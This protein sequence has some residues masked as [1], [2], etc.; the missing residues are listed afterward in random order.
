SPCK[1]GLILP[2][3][4]KKRAN[5]VHHARNSHRLRSRQ[6]AHLTLLRFRLHKIRHRNHAVDGPK[7]SFAVCRPLHQPGHRCKARS[8]G[9]GQARPC[10]HVR[11]A[12][13]GV[14]DDRRLRGFADLGISTCGGQGLGKCRRRWRRTLGVDVL[15]EA[16]VA[17]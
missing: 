14:A 13:H 2:Q 4:S 7:P 5:V 15:G 12:P 9:Q 1:T 3:S 16:V 11:L 8:A 17:E 6:A 10:H